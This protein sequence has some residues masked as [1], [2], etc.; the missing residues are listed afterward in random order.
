MK[1][2]YQIT[3]ASRP[4]VLMRLVQLFDQQSLVI[5]SLE[6]ALLDNRVRINLTVE[7]ERE[8]ALRLQAKLYHQMDIENVDL[9]AR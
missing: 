7:V 8:L 6:L 1:W 5:R 2:T 3:A 9:L 4:R